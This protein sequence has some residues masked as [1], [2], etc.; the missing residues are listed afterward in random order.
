MANDAAAHPIDDIASQLDEVTQNGDATFGDVIS[1]FGRTAF[2]TVL[3]MSALVLASPLS[4]VPFASTVFGM[5]I[6]VI[7]GQAAIGT[8]TVWLPDFLMRKTVTADRVAKLQSTLHRFG[9]FF[10]KFRRARL[11][12][13]VGRAGQH[14]LFGI[15]AVAGVFLPVLEFVPFSSS[16]A[17]AGIAL[18]M[19]GVIGR[20]GLFV[21]FGLPLVGGALS[22]PFF[23]YSSLFG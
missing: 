11:R 2:S 22:M 6:F 8:Q 12:G 18:T 7:A 17:G 19:L 16:I 10:D 23:V 3:L 20:D 14:V 4:G 9:T 15:C 21:L 1:K 5:L 13:V